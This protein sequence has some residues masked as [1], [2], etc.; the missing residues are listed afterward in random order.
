METQDI[1]KTDKESLSLEYTA[2]GLANWT[3]RLKADLIDDE[4]I[5]RLVDLNNVMQSKFPVNVMNR[6]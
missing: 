3:I 6:E 5:K 1:I 2:K 4:T